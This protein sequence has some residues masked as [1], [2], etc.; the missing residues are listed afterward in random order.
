MNVQAYILNI[1]GIQTIEEL[2]EM[3]NNGYAHTVEHS[4]LMG[5]NE[6]SHW[7]APK[8]IMTGDIVFFYHAIT[9]NQH[10]KRLRKQI[11]NGDFED[12]KKLLE[13]LDYCDS[14][15]EK[16][17]GKIYA[18]GIVSDSAYYSDSG[19]EHPHFKTRIF[20]PIENI[21][22][23][24][25]PLSSKQFND[26]L[27]IA[28]QSGVTPVFGNDFMKLKSLILR[29]NTVPYLEKCKSV[30]IPLKDIKKGTWIYS[31]N[32]NRRKYLYEAQFRK[33]YVDYMLMCLAD[34]NKYMSEVS[35]IKNSKISGRADNCIK[36]NEKY[37]FVEVKLNA[38]AE[39]D[40]IGQIEQY[41]RVDSFKIQNKEI[42]KDCIHQN[43]VLIIDINRI[44]MYDTAQD[45]TITEV[46]E[47]DRV[48]SMMDI[49]KIK[50]TMRILIN[51]I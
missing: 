21:V 28:R 37:L 20:A 39:D 45:D 46:A 23:F 19:W 33:Y 11:K 47:L 5:Q 14:L 41:S 51:D 25:Y 50:D 9:A 15:Y 18:A 43:N 22:N 13:Y 6:V 16:Y 26:F 4:I 10:T 38:L 31:A 24:D 42:P 30:S 40:V 7:T 1:S 48:K 49:R 12:S 44:Y 34:D 29:Y 32:E 27:P 8:W 36:F 2:R 35:C 17:G 3:V